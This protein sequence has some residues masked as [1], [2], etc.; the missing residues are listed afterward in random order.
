MGGI[1]IELYWVGLDWIGFRE[2]KMSESIMVNIQELETT[3]YIKW[4]NKSL[5]IISRSGV[6]NPAKVLRWLLYTFPEDHLIESK[7][8]SKDIVKLGLCDEGRFSTFFRDPLVKNGIL[9]WHSGQDDKKVIKIGP[10]FLEY[11]KEAWRFNYAEAHHRRDHVSTK[12]FRGLAT[13]V[14]SLRLKDEEKQK[15]IDNQQKRLENVE[16]ILQ[17]HEDVLVKLEA[18]DRVMDALMRLNPP[19]TPERREAFIKGD[20]KLDLA[21][22]PF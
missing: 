17:N 16:K 18:L 13:E 7:I 21:P 14:A 5:K 8:L 1:R 20:L 10:K 3:S 9:R 2:R 12:I 11:M 4:Y 19:D 22:A 6:E 15:K